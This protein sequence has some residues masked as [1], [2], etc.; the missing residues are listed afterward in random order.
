MARSPKRNDSPETDADAFFADVAACQANA[1]AFGNVHVTESVAV[2]R[3]APTAAAPT[4]ATEGADTMTEP[5]TARCHHGLDFLACH[6]HA[7]GTACHLDGCDLGI[8]TTLCPSCQGHGFETLHRADGPTAGERQTCPLCDGERIVAVDWYERKHGTD[9]APTPD[10]AGITAPTPKRI[11]R[12][13]GCHGDVFA[14]DA[15]C[16][17]CGVK[18]GGSA[19]IDTTVTTGRQMGYVCKLGETGKRFIRATRHLAPEQP[20]WI[21]TPTRD[22][23]PSPSVYH[24]RNR[25]HAQA[26]CAALAA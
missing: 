14:G 19:T 4:P 8:R 24:F 2:V 17:G 20:V 5:T 9:A 25:S 7:D 13:A 11:R 16:G 3:M 22:G 1:R 10:S 21:V 15:Y 12:C 26:W 6:L 18:L 23:A